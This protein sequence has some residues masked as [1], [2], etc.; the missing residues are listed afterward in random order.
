MQ[1]KQDDYV[2]GRQVEVDDNKLNLLVIANENSSKTG[3]LLLIV[4]VVHR[5]QD[6]SEYLRQIVHMFAPLMENN[7]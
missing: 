7:I 6:L 2:K 4:Y 5:A 3:E 1:E